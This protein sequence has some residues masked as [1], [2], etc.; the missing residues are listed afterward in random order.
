MDWKNI[1]KW[2]SSMFISLYNYYMS[3]RWDKVVQS[4]FFSNFRHTKGLNEV[5]QLILETTPSHER[6]LDLVGIMIISLSSNTTAE[7][8]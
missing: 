8:Y 2:L 1:L 4:F 6:R 5:K 3:D 7:Y